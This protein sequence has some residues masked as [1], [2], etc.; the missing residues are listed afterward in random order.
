MDERPFRVEYAIRTGIDD[1]VI[2]TG[3]HELTAADPAAA[4]AAT[5]A[6]AHA[7]HPH[8]DP[9]IDPAV[10]VLGVSASGTA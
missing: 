5:V 7:E 9:R 4:A 8:A 1:S 3:S 2:S 6:W 10:Q